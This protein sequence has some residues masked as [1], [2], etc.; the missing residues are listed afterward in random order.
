MINCNVEST[1]AIVVLLCVIVI[2]KSLKCW[3][4]NYVIAKN[5]TTNSSLNSLQRKHFSAVV[6]CLQS[7]FL[8]LTCVQLESTN[9]CRKC[10]CNNSYKT[11]QP[12]FIK[13]NWNSSSKHNLFQTLTEHGL[14]NE[15]NPY[16]VLATLIICFKITFLS[17]ISFFSYVSHSCWILTRMSWLD[18]FSKIN[19]YFCFSWHMCVRT[20]VVWVFLLFLFLEVL[21]CRNFASSQLNL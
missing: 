13:W 12:L 17:N 15:T 5:F 10:N 9:T 7:L 4:K 2:S 3:S 6:V 1:R 18:M 19:F 20:Y 14:L 16:K 11:A 8:L 21:N